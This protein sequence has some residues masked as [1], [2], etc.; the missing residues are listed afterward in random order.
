ML[1]KKSAT[2]KQECPVKKGTSSSF[3]T[4]IREIFEDEVSSLSHKAK[5]K[6]SQG[7]V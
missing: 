3:I 6:Q 5:R 2:M 1:Y 4:L 7:A